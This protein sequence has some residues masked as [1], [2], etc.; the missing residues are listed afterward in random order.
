[1]TFLP[2]ATSDLAHTTILKVREKNSFITMNSSSGITSTAVSG[3]STGIDGLTLI[4]LCHLYASVTQW[5]SAGNTGVNNSMISGTDANNMTF[6]FSSPDCTYY[7]SLMKQGYGVCAYKGK[8]LRNEYKLKWDQATNCL[9]YHFMT[10]IGASGQCG[11]I[12]EVNDTKN[13]TTMTLISKDRHFYSFITKFIDVKRMCTNANMAMNFE[14]QMKEGIFSGRNCEIYRRFVSLNFEKICSYNTDYKTR[15]SYYTCTWYHFM[16]DLGAERVCHAKNQHVNRPTDNITSTAVSVASTDIDGLTLIILCH[17]YASVKQWLFAGNT[18]VNNSMVSGTDTND[19]TF[20]FSPPDCTKYNLLTENGYGLCADKGVLPRA[21]LRDNKLR[22]IRAA[23]C[24]FYHFMIRMGAS[25]QCENISAMNYTKNETTMTLL[26]KDRHFYSFITKFIDVKRMCTNT[27]MAINFENQMKEGILSEYNC[28]VYREE[29]SLNY[30]KMCTYNTDCKT[31]HPH[32][33][34][35]WHR[36]MADLGAE[37]VCQAN[38]QHG[39][40]PTDNINSTAVSVEGTNIDGIT[41]ILCHLYASVMQWLSA[42]NTGVHNS[43]I[44][45]TDANDMTFIFSPPD[46][47][48]YNLLS[49]SGYSDCE[50]TY[51]GVVHA[52]RSKNKQRWTKA[53]N[54]LL[55]HFMIKMGARGQC[56]NISEVN[57]TTNETAMTLISKDRH[58]YSFITEFIDVKRMCTNT[59]MAMNIERQMKEGILNKRNCEIYHKEVSHNYEMMCTYNTDCKTLPSHYECTWFHFTPCIHRAAI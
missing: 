30:E 52:L 5:L 29:V 47:T 27:I 59:K 7:N 44:S 28:E 31:L 8:V 37:S 56:T 34:C 50:C 15:L 9:F 14:R 11:N 48:Q 55:Y 51:K 33:E 40:K 53:L 19:M 6:K 13:E 2:L 16:A 17:L 24:V 18:G 20:I 45:G 21:V 54:C 1:M 35:T 46:C 36:F 23:N 10:K 32:Y 26:S 39:N 38:N 25:R 58:L 12:S 49:E 4:I 3:T 43:I 41:L 42:G 57:D 22:W